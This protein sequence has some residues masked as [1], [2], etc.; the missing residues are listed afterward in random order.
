ML[1]QSCG[2]W[3]GTSKV[4]WDHI[5]QSQRSD[6]VSRGPKDTLAFLYCILGNGTQQK[7][8]TGHEVPVEHETNSK[9]I[10]SRQAV[11]IVLLAYL[12]FTVH[13]VVKS[14]RL[15]RLL[16]TPSYCCDKTVTE[17]TH[18]RKSLCSLKVPDGI[19][20]QQAVGMQQEQGAQRHFAS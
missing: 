14:G 13:S 20:R 7:Q 16:L 15:E 11:T 8:S 5:Q 4:F 18:E 17:A 19:A 12:K 10:F 1:S 2:K 9:C 6:A 3:H